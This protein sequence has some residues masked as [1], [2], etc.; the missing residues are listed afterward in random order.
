[1]AAL[2]AIRAKTLGPM[3]EL[4][5]RLATC[6]HISGLSDAMFHG[7]R[8]QNTKSMFGWELQVL[9]DNPFEWKMEHIL[10]LH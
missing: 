9:T 8:K 10:H 6:K 5:T 2:Y 3:K 7:N 4:C 1:M